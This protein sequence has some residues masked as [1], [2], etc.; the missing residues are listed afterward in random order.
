MF[1][2]TREDAV[3]EGDLSAFSTFLVHVKFMGGSALADSYVERE[4][5]KGT[6]EP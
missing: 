1:G 3:F 5:C 4:L 2:T 6:G